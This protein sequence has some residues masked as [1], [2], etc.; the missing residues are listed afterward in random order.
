MKRMKRTLGGKQY[1][2]ETARLLKRH[3]GDGMVES[4]YY[5]KSR[6]FFL[7]GTGDKDSRYAKK[8][9][10]GF[11]AGQDIIPLTEDAAR[12]WFEEHYSLTTWNEIMTL[13]DEGTVTVT[14]RLPPSVKERFEKGKDARGMNAGQY[15]DHLLNLETENR[16]MRNAT[17]YKDDRAKEIAENLRKGDQWDM[18]LLKE[19]CEIAGLSDDWKDADGETFEHVAYKAAEILGVEI[20]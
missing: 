10:D 14:F 6:Q 1:D 12:A 13:I 9:R 15:L 5:T 18:D 3:G 4:L 20:V 7:H 16:K 11:A 2:T 8:T 17:D 19:L